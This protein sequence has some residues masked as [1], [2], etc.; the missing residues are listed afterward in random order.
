MTDRAEN[1]SPSTS[2]GSPKEDKKQDEGGMSHLLNNEQ[3][4]FSYTDSTAW[5]LYGISFFCA[6]ASGTL[7]PLMTLVFGGFITRIS[8]FDIGIMTP[9]EFRSEVDSFSRWFLYL[10]VAR[11]I[12]TYVFSVTI[13][14]AAI[15]TTKAIRVEFLNKTLRQDISYFDTAAKGATAMQV[16]TNGNLINQGIAEKLGMTIQAIS[17]IITAF[18]L[19]LVVQW[20]LT[21]IAIGI[22]PFM[23]AVMTVCIGIDA[24][25]EKE[26]LEHYS[27]AGSL[28]EE[29]FSSVRTLQAFWARPRLSK[30][31]DHLMN[32]AH[33][34]G[35]KKSPNYGVFFSLEF[36]CIFSA[37]GLVFWQ[38]VRMYARGEISDPGDVV[39]VLFSVIMAATGVTQ[40][41]PHAMAFSKAASAAAELFKTIDRSSDIDPLSESGLTPEG[42]SGAIDIRNVQFSYPSRPTYQVLRG[43]DLH[44]PAGKTTALVGPSGCGKSTVVGLIERWYN[45][46]EGSIRL[47]G[48][49]ITELNVR[50][51]R[52]QIRLVQQEPVLFNGTVFQNVCYGLIGTPMEN[53]TEEEQMKH[54]VEA[55]N[56][57]NAHE[58][59]VDLPKGYYT[60]IGE[61]AGMLSGGQKQRIAIARSIISNPKVLLLDEATSALDP[62]AEKT[63]QAAI[64]KVSANR[65]TLVIAHKLAT[66]KNADNI[67]VITQGQVAEQG[68]HEELIAAGGLYAHLVGAQDLGDTDERSEQGD[69]ISSASLDDPLALV[70]TPTSRRG[71]QA[72]TPTGDAKS[73]ETGS[74]LK[75]S[76]LKCIY[77]F[78][79]EQKGLGFQ[80]AV[81][82]AMCIVGGLTFPAQAILFSRLVNV[83]TLQ[84]DRMVDRG[85]FFALMFFMV[86]VGNLIGYF[87]MGWVSN[88]IAQK[89]THRYRLEIFDTLLRQ[90]MEFFDKPE[91]TVGSL[92]SK[93]STE[94]TQLQDLLGFNTPLILIVIV[95]IIGSCLLAIIVGW[96]L[97][98][99][100]IFGG[101]PAL[102]FCGYLRIRLEM[103]FDALSG[104][105]FAQSASLASEAVSAIRTVASMTME[106]HILSEYRDRMNGIVHRSIKNVIWTMFWYALAQSIE[107]LVMGL[108]FWYGGHLVSTGEYSTNQFFI[109]FIGVLFSGQAAAQFFAYTTSITKAHSS[110]NWIM[111]LRSLKPKM[112]EHDKS[113]DSQSDKEPDG[114]GLVELENVEFSY[115][116]RPDTRVL[117]RMNIT[118]RP[119]EFTAFVGASGCGKST[120][121]ALLERF[122]DPNSGCI[123]FDGKDISNMCPRVYRSRVA[124][125]QQEPT[126]YQGSIRENIAMGLS[127]DATFEK[128]EEASKQANAFTFISSLPDGFSTLCGSRGVQLSGGQ[129]QRIAIARALIRQ[130]KLLL[131]DEATS[132]LD[133]DSEKVVQEALA[134]AASGR[135]TVAVAHRLSTIK[136]ASMIFVFGKGKVLESGTHTQLLNRKGIY[137]EMCLA[138]SLDQRLPEKEE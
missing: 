57:S 94:P 87:I 43:L 77:I 9:A 58:F 105:R 68:T 73:H 117:R 91:N 61:R 47:D 6:A 71:S 119:G 128:I 124:L 131:L 137:Y 30:K 63:V 62:H 46:G 122:Y 3:R 136:D 127:T 1:E 118:I 121:I 126:L 82:F 66:I 99:V 102:I 134:Q 100:V 101:L 75:H 110:A 15:R 56:L 23:A 54:V 88:L 27:M 12:L 138:Q 44:I 107:F 2:D 4:V 93:L 34:I 45:V 132:A 7:T 13:T 67:A 115:P 35:N 8:N 48:R 22:M 106:R 49:D 69:H 108:G 89:L 70:R 135:T 84:R 24:R 123:K 116:Q 133:T 50:W 39:T 78:L 38:G 98:L 90:D 60:E 74:K 120:I 96:K 10:F 42:T 95:N 109:V 72:V 26:I 64:D 65:T 129:R 16:T 114:D 41:A 18:V 53:E 36:F 52:S 76:L 80:Y 85:D 28:A 19:A 32:L 21:L 113:H 25:Q 83:F 79:R 103:K 20:K 125:V 31:Y 81:V 55:C 112:E 37:Y 111:W 11:L 51:L 130:P 29:A 92:T 17:T 33:L 59:I 14:V 97:G 5:A 86:A 104:M 40:I